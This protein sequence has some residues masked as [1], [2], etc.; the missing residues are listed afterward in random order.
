[1]TGTGGREEKIFDA[2]RKKGTR[3]T[4]Q[5]T[6]IVR[7]L[8]RRGDHPSAGVILREARKKVPGMSASTVY[9]TLGL[10]KKE[11]LIKELEFTNMEDRYESVM[12]DHIDLVCVRCGGI[13]N[14]NI[15]LS[16]TYEAVEKVT[17][18]RAHGMRFEYHGLCAKC[19]EG[20][21]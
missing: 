16:A 14:L 11:G 12:T 9:Y 17:G 1:M 13:E 8:C 21:E 19:R 18:F 3:L 7:I 15:E 5:R 4:P 20:K 10:L 6:E 2:L